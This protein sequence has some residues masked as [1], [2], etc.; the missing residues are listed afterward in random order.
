MI[1]H[2]DRRT[3]DANQ[4]INREKLTSVERRDFSSRASSSKTRRRMESGRKP[5]EEY[6][7][8]A[9]IA[10][11]RTSSG[12]PFRDFPGKLTVKFD[13]YSRLFFVRFHP[14]F[15]PSYLGSLI[16]SIYPNLRG[17][18][19]LSSWS[20][21]NDTLNLTFNRCIYRQLYIIRE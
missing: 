13:S 16:C 17:W 1:Q 4:S 20:I 19:K 11:S 18:F 15:L 5:V 14:R 12:L 21:C 6:Q 10:S 7:F 3:L 8:P 9:S 2:V